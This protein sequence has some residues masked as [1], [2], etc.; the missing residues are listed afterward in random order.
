MERDPTGIGRTGGTTVL[1]ETTLHESLDAPAPADGLPARLGRYIPLATLGAGGMGVVYAAYDTE[2]ARRVAVKV[3]PHGRRWAINAAP[4]L[5]R[6][7]R[8]LARLAHPNVVAIYDVGETDGTVYVAMEL[9]EGRTLTAWQSAQPRPW[10]EVV[11]AYLQAGEGLDAAHAE[12]LVHRDFKPD[13]AIIDGH[14]RVRVLDFG[15]AVAPADD[16]DDEPAPE[17]GVSVFARL[18]AT[19]T[20]MGTPAY[21]A[22]EQMAG[23]EADARSDQFSFCV[24]LFE[25]LHGVRP[26]PGRNIRDIEGAILRSELVDSERS[27]PAWLRRLVLRG[28]RHDPQE[29][30]PDMAALLTALRRGRRR[31]G[32]GRRWMAG[33]GLL[34]VGAIGLATP[35]GLAGRRCDTV[36]DPMQRAWNAEARHDVRAALLGSD[37]PYA[38]D[39]WSR[40]QPGLDRYAREWSQQRQ[41]VCE[42]GRREAISRAVHDLRVA[43]LDERRAELEG[44]VE[45]LRDA[46]DA[47]VAQA[48]DAVAGLGGVH[49]CADVEV[50]RDAPAQPVDAARLAEVLDALGRAHALE[51][52]GRYAEGL[53][54]AREAAR[55]ADG[56]GDPALV[57]EAG[58]RVGRLHERLGDYPDAEQALSRAAWLAVEVRHD[59]VAARAM[60]QLTGIVGYLQA[61]RD[62]GLDWG[63]H[64]AAAVARADSDARER[65]RLSNNLGAVHDRAGDLIRAREHY[66]RAL[67]QLEGLTDD[68]SR[69]ERAH[70]LN[71]LANTAAR[72]GEL[73]R[74]Q[75]DLEAALALTE[76]LRGLDHPQVA[77]MLANL[78]NVELDRGSFDDAERHQRR[79]LDIRER[80]LGADHP[81]V[82]SSL[83]NLGNVANAK[84]DALGALPLFERAVAVK[85][86]ALGADHHQT[87]IALNNLG[88]VLRDLG[89]VSEA[90]EAHRR[91]L[92]IWTTQLGPTHPLIAYPA[93]N[94]GLDLLADGR[95]EAAA[96]H[97]RRALELREQA[98]AE[99][100]LRGISRLGL[101]RAMEAMGDDP[102]EVRAMGR[103]A[104]AELAD[105]P[106]RFARHR[107][108][109]RDWLD[110]HP[111]SEPSVP[112]P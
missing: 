42:A 44:L 101:A 100:P 14:A 111:E 31:A 50:R 98:G 102:Q 88:D 2:L 81:L 16:E 97:L 67:A 110:A 79:A 34:L 43:C 94:L 21:M 27:V 105:A 73:P 29:R 5:R 109:A 8:A 32:R 18:T 92:D 65:A 91:A 103:A 96:E 36:A 82:G 30:W 112:A 89:R 62:D 24:A 99:P 28:L 3:L 104:W 78:A 4:R 60:I 93:T 45:V 12:G 95:P 35:H 9:V 53:E 66:S 40:V 90:I 47:V 48:A 83:L 39:T 84:G 68:A 76:A 56:L 37:R 58:L 77:I 6:E 11:D 108:N 87:A 19:G 86:A 7:A 72:L 69:Q 55:L 25:A 57:A 23:E 15:L 22:P 17:A 1:G 85:T 52:A 80:S 33:G 71:N 74:A 38:A 13:N 54:S 10:T 26:F 63:R 106:V 61:R 20:I 41:A 59:E 70:T 51:L 46:D 75:T 49:R 64:A 107:Q